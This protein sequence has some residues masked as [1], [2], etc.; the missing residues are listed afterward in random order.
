VWGSSAN[1]VYV[2][3]ARTF[4]HTKNN[5]KSWVSR[6]LG[7]LDGISAD[8]VWGSS[9]KDMYII[10]S[11]FE[12]LFTH[13]AGKTWQSTG[14]KFEFNEELRALRAIWGSSATDLYAVGNYLFWHSQDAG[15]TW[16]DVMVDTSEPGIISSGP[17]SAVW[18]S[19][20]S[21]VYVVGSNGVIL[22]SADAGKSWQQNFPLR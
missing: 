14:Q 21:D 2:G 12:V 8:Y 1:D 4:L 18:G 17:F 3:G 9:A 10:A 13:N 20:A 22:H 16:Q 7:A 5:G 11:D 6:S 19:S 15:K